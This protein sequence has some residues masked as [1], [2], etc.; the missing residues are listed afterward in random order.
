MQKDMHAHVYTQKCAHT[1]TCIILNFLCLAFRCMSACFR[2]AHPEMHT[3]KDALVLILS[4][5]H[6][7]CGHMHTYSALHMYRKCTQSVQ[8]QSLCGS[9]GCQYFRV[10]LPE[11]LANEVC[12]KHHCGGTGLRLDVVTYQCHLT[13]W[14]W[15][16]P[17]LGDT[18]IL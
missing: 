7:K 9:I 15:P 10:F 16:C 2:W 3:H 14:P 12:V 5:C 11:L 6:L 18:C 17:H 8:C 13:P 1:H 4:L